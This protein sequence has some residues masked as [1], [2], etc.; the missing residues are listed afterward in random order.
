MKQSVLI[1][2]DGIME[3]IKMVH[4]LVVLALGGVILCPFYIIFKVW[5]YVSEW[6]EKRK[7][8]THV[9]PDKKGKFLFNEDRKLMMECNELV[10]VETTYNEWMHRFMENNTEWLDKWQKW[11]GCEIKI[12]SSEEIREGMMYEEDFAVFE[13]GFLWRSPMKTCDNVS[14]R[15]GEICL[16]YEMPPATDAEIREQMESMMSKI[17]NEID[18]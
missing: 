7:K 4:L 13:H 14:G 11:H 2:L 15:F 17:Y 10:Y 3:N 18:I 8:K 12:Y 1:R 5:D 9:I 6:L 16:Y